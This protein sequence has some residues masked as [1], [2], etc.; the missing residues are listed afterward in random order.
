[1]L[2]TVYST[3]YTKK[4]S[5]GDEVGKCKSSFVSH[6]IVL[7]ATMEQVFNTGEDNFNDGHDRILAWKKSNNLLSV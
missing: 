1:M 4:T 6:S 7:N 5:F 2:I 3:I